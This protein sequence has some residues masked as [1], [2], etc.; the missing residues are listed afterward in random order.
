MRYIARLKPNIFM[1]DLYKDKGMNALSELFV[2]EYGFKKE[3]VRTLVLKFPSILSMPI[4]Y[5]RKFFNIM[6]KEKGID[7]N[8]AMRMVFDVP[9]LLRVDLNAKA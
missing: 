3:L 9:E 7:R 8:T 5:L 6:T 2:K 1:Y 4:G